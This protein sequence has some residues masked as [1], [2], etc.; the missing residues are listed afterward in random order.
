MSEKLMGRYDVLNELGQ[1]SQSIVYLA[2]DS[3]MTRQ[4]VVKKIGPGTTTQNDIL[5][6][7][8]RAA[9]KLHHQNII[10]FYDL[11]VING[12][13]YFVYAH[14][15]SESLAQFL[16][17]SG[18]LSVS[19]AIRIT[20]EVLDALGNAHGQGV[21]H[22][23]LK[24]ANVMIS[25]SGQHL[26]V[27]FGIE[28]ALTGKNVS[29][30]SSKAAL[31]RAPETVSDQGTELR[32]DLYSVG[33]MLNEMVTGSP[34]L[35]GR[36]TDKVTDA[37]VEADEKLAKIILKATEKNPADRYSNA[38]DMRQALIDYQD[39]IKAALVGIPSADFASTLKFLVRR[40]RSKNDFPA[41][42]GIIN[43]INKIVDSDTEGSGKLA[44]VI[45]QDYSLTNKLL[46]LV[47]TVSYSQFGGKINTISKAV[48]ILGV[49][50]VRN[51]A[52][53][54]IVM[55]FLQN[56]TQAQEL[57]DVV[58]TSFFSGIV[59]AKLSPWK[60][61]Q[62][63]EEAMIC[64]M[65]F[66]L[67]RMLA[68]FY[69]FD[70]CEEI[71][72]VMKEQRLDE[73]SA[74]KEVLGISYNDLGIGI[75][76]SWNFPETLLLGMKKIAGDISFVSEETSGRLN[77]AVNMANELSQITAEEDANARSDALNK[78]T[79]RYAAVEGVSEENLSSALVK[80]LQ[81]L[82]QRSTVFGIDASKSPMLKNMKAWVA[83][84][85]NIRDGG[86]A[87][88]SDQLTD[89]EN[90]VEEENIE[91]KNAEAFLKEGIQDIS[92]TMN[93]EYKLNDVLQMVLETI[94]RGLDFKH[95][96]IFS[97]DVKKNMMVARF[98][99]GANIA[100]LLPHFNFPLN[101]DADV[102]HFA[103][104]KGLDI[105]IEDVAAPNIASKIPGWYAKAI[106]S[107]Y[108]LLLP[109][110]VKNLPVG[111]IYADMT[112]AKK[113]KISAVEMS[114]LRDLRNLALTAIKQKTQV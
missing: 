77:V 49:E 8:A 29:N 68:K 12:F 35:Q 91:K 53:S 57:K 55:D 54:L 39:A 45:L 50:P 101:F 25:A 78:I 96:F 32:S 109:M 69:L 64:S 71:D 22:L 106:D 65:F 7:E 41:M 70:E 43:E 6:S 27:D 80:G 56:K 62:E 9:S 107:R 58:V 85:Q 67:G 19:Q 82:T 72:R 30:V 18:A 60:N 63:V 108:F 24:P 51:I 47:N 31:Y 52:M 87:A 111:L 40:I 95:V 10:P 86:T 98:G 114:L 11:G 36:N 48:A 26:L 28:H 38:M 4:V 59:A 15:S 83:H 103:M 42:S 102:F 93:S 5:L 1:S 37:T 94:Y 113:L 20:L 33:I 34:Y 23:G 88:T 92:N 21:V 13:A 2:R 110:V 16:K 89:T 75:A 90:L 66:N 14:V 76:K 3:R 100:D 99:F 61:A 81:E 17:R 97:R 104:A 46:R 105:V 73:E 74:A 112:E 84:V 79:S 44:Q